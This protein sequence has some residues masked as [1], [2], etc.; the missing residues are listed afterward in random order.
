M[1]R[2]D[3]DYVVVVK[4]YRSFTAGVSEY[5][6]V[7]AVGPFD[8]ELGTPS[9]LQGAPRRPAYTG[10]KWLIF[11]A[12]NIHSV[13]GIAWADVPPQYRSDAHIKQF[14][15]LMVREDVRTTDFILNIV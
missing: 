12:S 11:T 8:I 9:S 13:A 1:Q 2:P 4:R 14:P 5:S 7:G 3:Y 6:S 15:C 10:Y